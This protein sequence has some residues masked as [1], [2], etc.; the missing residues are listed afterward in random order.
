M[1]SFAVS[2]PFGGF[3]SV[4]LSTDNAPILPLL[5]CCPGDAVRL[6]AMVLT[7]RVRLSTAR[8]H[9]MSNPMGVREH[10]QGMETARTPWLLRWEEEVSKLDELLALLTAAPPSP[11]CEIA[12]EHVQ[13]ARSC[14]LGAMPAECELDLKLARDS[15]GRI[16]DRLTRRS[17]EDILVSLPSSSLA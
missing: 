16:T 7:F 12:Q 3:C 1:R 11:D 13:C 8:L 2:I 9:S 4:R 5:T 15:I 10:R 6:V 14:V 17:A